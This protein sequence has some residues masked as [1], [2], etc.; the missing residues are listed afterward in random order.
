M[1]AM[2]SQI[3]GVPI[4]YST[5]C[6]GADPRKH[7]SSASLA[8]VRV[9]HRWPVNSPHKGPVTRASNAENASIWWRHHKPSTSC[10]Q[11][12]GVLCQKKQVSRAGISKY[13]PRIMW[14][15]IIY[16][17]PWY[18]TISKQFF[19]ALYWSM[20]KQTAQKCCKYIWD[21]TQSNLYFISSLHWDRQ[22]VVENRCQ[23]TGWWRHISIAYFM[24]NNRAGSIIC[25]PLTVP[26]TEVNQLNH[27]RQLDFIDQHSNTP[28]TES[29]PY[30]KRRCFL[31][32]Y[33]LCDCAHD[34]LSLSIWW[35]L[36]FSISEIK[37]SDINESGDFPISVNYLT[38]RCR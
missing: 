22:M 31:T 27:F 32:G 25:L 21:S 35:G 2:A 7:Q 26:D 3:T 1:S 33:W 17:C 16:F 24:H 29:R 12:S 38:F 20:E 28:M 18:H 30:G 9:I 11:K 14:R 23:S 6:L 10:R 36:C 5:V 13:I 8:F 34:D 37:C 19:K 4:V 15:V